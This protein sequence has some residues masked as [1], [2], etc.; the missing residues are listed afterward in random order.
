MMILPTTVRNIRG[1]CNKAEGEDDDGVV[2]VVVVACGLL[3]SFIVRR[4]ASRLRLT[5]VSDFPG[6]SSNRLDGFG[7]VVEE[8]VG[9][10]ATK[11]K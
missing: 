5:L 1:C 6:G 9:A 3:R 11:C 7:V 4:V 8:V 2:A 10:M